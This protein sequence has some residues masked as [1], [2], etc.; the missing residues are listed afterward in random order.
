MLFAKARKEHLRPYR[1]RHYCKKH[2][3]L[4]RD[5]HGCGSCARDW[6]REQGCEPARWA[7][8]ELDKLNESVSRG[9]YDFSA[10]A[11]DQG[12]NDGYAEGR[13]SVDQW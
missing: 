1:D 5:P 6:I 10:G 9:D 13:Q 11:Y 3:H 8:A 7:L 4:V 2:R 12:H